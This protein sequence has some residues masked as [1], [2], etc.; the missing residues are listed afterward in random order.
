VLVLC[1]GSARAATSPVFERADGTSIAF[2]G[3]VRAW[4]DRGRLYVVTLGTIRQSRWQLSLTRTSVR[5]GRAVAFT[6][7]RP[8]GVEL[9]V[10][11]AKTR[12]EASEGAEGSDGRVRLRRATCARGGKLEI[13]LSGIL[14][15]EFSDGKRIRASGLFAGRVGTRPS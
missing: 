13:A 2:P 3:T 12:N 7:R 4:C 8:N 10:F 9:F 6:W 1:A 5:D 14:A 15:S 11:D